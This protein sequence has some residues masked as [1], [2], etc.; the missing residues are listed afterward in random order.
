MLSHMNGYCTSL[1]T[2]ASEVLP[3]KWIRSFLSDRS[4]QVVVD[5]EKS[6]PA[7]VT[8]GVSQGSVLGPILFQMFINDMPVCITAK[9]RIFANNF[10]IYQPVSNVQDCEALQNDLDALQV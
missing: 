10:I 6:T 5:G 7:P 1:N 3:P 4:K 2:M 8:S 9:C